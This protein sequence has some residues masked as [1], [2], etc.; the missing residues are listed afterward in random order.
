MNKIVN[1]VKEKLIE[2]IKNL[3]GKNYDISV[4]FNQNISINT[5]YYEKPVISKLKLIWIYKNVIEFTFNDYRSN[6]IHET[7]IKFSLLDLQYVKIRLYL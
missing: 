3:I 4:Y 6:N 7:L 1:G 2:E 5:F